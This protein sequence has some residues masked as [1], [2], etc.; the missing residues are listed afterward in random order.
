MYNLML[1][2]DLLAEIERIML[3]AFLFHKIIS[4]EEIVDI[5]NNFFTTEEYTNWIEQFPE[6]SSI[7]KSNTIIN[8]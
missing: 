6:L 8:L 5:I 7:Y 1:T 2:E 3:Y 4:K